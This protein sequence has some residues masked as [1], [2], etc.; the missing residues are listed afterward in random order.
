MFATA[1]IMLP[2]K[3]RAVFIPTRALFYDNTTDAYHVYSVVNGIAR[4]N[5]VQLGNVQGDEVRILRGLT[6][7]EM[8]VL[9]NQ[10]DLFDGATVN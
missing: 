8:V 6:G 2:E 4:L 10:A 7:D 9:N 1:R 3:E 5:V